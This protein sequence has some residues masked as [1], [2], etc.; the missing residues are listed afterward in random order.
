MHDQSR[1]DDFVC[2]W[3][4]TG[5]KLVSFHLFLRMCV[6]AFKHLSNLI[7]S[8]SH[9]AYGGKRRRPWEQGWHLCL[10]VLSHLL[11]LLLLTL[12]V[13][14]LLAVYDF[15]NERDEVKTVNLGQPFS[16]PCPAHTPG[17]GIV[18]K[19]ESRDRENVFDRS[20]SRGITEDGTLY[21]MFMT[22]DDIK[23][24]EDYKG[25]KCVISAANVFY[26][27]GVFEVRKPD[28]SQIG[29]E[30]PMKLQ[31]NNTF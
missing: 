23:Q 7:P 3:D 17:F 6:M 25:I 30:L 26:S 29:K 18:Y 22:A 14:F 1:K 28:A 12:S 21:I 24:I 9:H 20:P 2:Q 19:W 15:T 27:S 4:L 5:A 10:V 8:S 16:L 11:Y 13:F 31:L